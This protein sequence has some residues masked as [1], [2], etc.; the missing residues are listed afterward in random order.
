MGQ[1]GGGGGRAW[2]WGGENDKIFLSLDPP[3]NAPHFP[4][5]PFCAGP[6]HGPRTLALRHSAPCAPPK[7]RARIGGAKAEER[8]GDLWRRRGKQLP[9]STF[10]RLGAIAPR[11]ALQRSM[12]TLAPAARAVEGVLWMSR[13][14][15]R[16]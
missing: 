16:G 11:C 8:A 14:S 15:E 6:F 5:R 7:P 3:T 4:T 10:A 1:R 13:G 2:P 9:L 12:L